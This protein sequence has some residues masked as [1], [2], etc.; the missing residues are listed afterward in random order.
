MEPGHLLHSALTRP[1]SANARRLKSRHT[2]LP[3]TQHL[4]SLSDKNNIRAAHWVDHQWNGEWT[5]STTRLRTYISDTDTHPLWATLPRTSWVQLNFLLTGVGRFLPCLYKWSS[6]WPP[7]RPVSVA[8]KNKP[9]TM[10]SY[11][12]QSIDILM[13]RTAW[14]LW[15]MRQSNDCSTPVPRSSAAWQWLWRTDSREEEASKF[16][17]SFCCFWQICFRGLCA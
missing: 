10:L 1:S 16:V 7:L 2:F 4:I 15:T 3:V 9:S 11:N 13:D 5:D 17:L 6:V 12:V 14:R 8:Q